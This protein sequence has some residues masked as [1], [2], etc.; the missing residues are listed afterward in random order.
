MITEI[1]ALPFDLNDI[2][3]LEGL[4]DKV[5]RVQY[6]PT[7][8]IGYIYFEGEFGHVARCTTLFDDDMTTAIAIGDYDAEDKLVGIE[9][10]HPRQRYSA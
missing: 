4:L 8:D 3:Y 9:M 5:S 2:S 1:N 7:Y 10:L 6:D